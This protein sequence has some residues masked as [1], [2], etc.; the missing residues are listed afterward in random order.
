MKG[1]FSRRTFDAARHYSG[2]LMQQGRVQLDADWN[3]QLGIQRHRDY[4]E[5]EDVI[6]RCGA[7]KH[8]AG[9]LVQPTP[10]GKDLVISPGRFYVH[11]RLCELES[12]H[13][14]AT[15]QSATQASVSLWHVDGADFAPNQWLELSA[16]NVAPA[17]ARVQAANPA[18]RQLT[19]A[20]SIAAFSAATA[21]RVRRLMTYLTQPDLPNPPFFSQPN[22][23]LPPELHLPDGTY[24]LYLDVWPRHI[25]ALDDDHI[26]EKALGGP[27]TATRVKTV[28]QLRLWPG[29]S[30]GAPLPGDTGCQS[31]VSGW[32][33][34][35]APPTG[36]LTA[37][38]KPAPDTDNPC[39]LPPAAGYLGLE[40]QLYRVEIHRGGALG[41]DT[42]T[43]KG[44]RDN[45]SV[46]KSIEKI[47]GSTDHT[48]HDTGPDD[49]LGL[50]NGQWVEQVDDVVEL[51]AIARNLF[52]FQKDPVTGAV[53]LP[54]PV[55]EARHPK[56]RRWDS[57]DEVTVPF[58]PV[59]DGFIDLEQGIQVRFDAGRY[60]TGDYWTILARTVL[61]DIEWRR[62]GA[63]NPV[64]EL[65]HGIHHV[66][67]RTGVLHVQGGALTVEDCRPVFPPLSELKSTS[68]CCTF[69]VGDGA[70]HVG[71][72]TLIQEAVNHLPSE[73]GEICIFPGTYVENVRIEGR[74]HV[75]IKGCGRRSRVVS[76]P[77]NADGVAAAVFHLV[78]TEDV[79]IESLAVEAA[80]AAPGILA[81][82]ERPNERVVLDRVWLTAARDSA[83][84]VRGGHDVTIERCRVQMTDMNGGWPGIFLRCTDGLVRDN[85]VEGM[86]HRMPPARA[87]NLPG[88]LA[89]SG[90]QLGG[91][92]ERVRV[93]ANLFRGCSGHGITLGS[94]IEVDRQDRPTDPA[95]G[96]GW[97]S[98][99]NDPCHPCEDPSTGDRPPREGDDEPPT[100][101]VSEGD[102]YD[103]DIRR[104]RILD[105]GLD[106]IGVAH[107][108]D[109]RRR[110]KHA[111][112]VRIEDLT[113]VDNRIER[114][115]RRAFAPIPAFMIDL[116]AY[117]GISLSLVEGLVIRDNRIDDVG[118]N[119]LLPVCG[120]FV[121]YTEGAEVARNQIVNSGRGTVESATTALPGRR[122][123]IHVVFALPLS[124]ELPP[125][126]SDAEPFRAF[127][128]SGVRRLDVAAAVEENTVDVIQGQALSL[129]ALGVVSVVSN[130]LISRGLVRRDLAGI[131]RGDTPAVGNAIT[132]L[133]SLVAIVNLGSA[134][135]SSGAVN[136]GSSLSSSAGRGIAAVSAMSPSGAVLFDDNVCSLR[137][138]DD[139]PQGTLPPAIVVLT[140]DDVGF[141]NNE[142]GC[143]IGHGLM[144]V[145][146]VLFGVSVRVVSNRLQE[147]L[148]RAQ[149]SAW[150]VGM[151]NMTALNQTNHCLLIVG[152]K[153]QQDQPNHVLIGIGN[154]Q[155]C[156]A[157]LR[158]VM[159]R[160]RAL[161]G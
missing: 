77:P 84:K 85:V 15:F 155:F 54:F 66:Y 68:S 64:S 105:D 102:L 122:G 99:R 76:A 65:R 139:R 9:F 11:G 12:T 156:P 97:V 2:V 95:G 128:P 83:I 43:F 98:D 14:S 87:F 34:A 142:C 150:T 90:L 27:D 6:G 20:S 22:P 24:L 36:R 41:T 159:E 96:G 117:G 33:A 133:A 52:Q 16:S 42:I 144:P 116:M 4:T 57:T 59:G 134:A 81:D 58:P 60:R 108:F 89:V 45:G 1:D 149:F 147:T 37:R 152:T 32:D 88:S 124:V 111:G 73:G 44:S 91:G 113:I 7:P 100:H 61:G 62:D 121:L 160:V 78:A 8:D 146:A 141:Q 79:T 82:G 50:A 48:V 31:T 49:V 114:V 119:G 136:V 5:A 47:A 30:D 123:G 74:R 25:I 23:A 118:V 145:A 38:T 115:V 110:L 151:M 10:D 157:A 158:D 40:N 3:E 101:L 129:G 125:S 18:T 67:C 143:V 92:S 130:R 35:T 29:P 69:T 19:F 53:T 80:P 72:F 56:L 13:V 21:F 71:D 46:V 39:L 140:L 103:I 153:L 63:G 26:R 93:H 17:V 51:H 127:M 137:L 161:T 94:V 138:D 109:L 135:A 132:H 28:W 106:G 107:F 131:V 120:I 86:L 55:D 154:P 70:T 104:N 148:G 126:S 75:H 112:L